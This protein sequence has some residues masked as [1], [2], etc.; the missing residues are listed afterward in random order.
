[1]KFNEYTLVPPDVQ[2]KLQAAYDAEQ[3]ED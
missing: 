2:E 1:M 3:D